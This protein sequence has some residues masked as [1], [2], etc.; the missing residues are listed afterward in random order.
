MEADCPPWPRPGAG[1][2]EA[3][4]AAKLRTG[5]SMQDPSGSRAV[6][7]DSSRKTKYCR[8]TPISQIESTDSRAGYCSPNRASRSSRGRP[9]WT[10][11]TRMHGTPR[12]QPSIFRYSIHRFRFDSMSISTHQLEKTAARAATYEPRA[13]R[14]PAQAPDASLSS[15]PSSPTDNLDRPQLP[16]SSEHR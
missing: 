7:D 3:T 4:C 8:L 1:L 16:M 5:T 12:P 14:R 10:P 15:F 2:G 6:E 11:Q 13:P 9:W